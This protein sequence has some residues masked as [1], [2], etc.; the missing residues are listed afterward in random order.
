MNVSVLGDLGQGV[1]TEGVDIPKSS[2]ICVSIFLLMK[3]GWMIAIKGV[4]SI[5]GI[6]RR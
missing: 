1:C 5:G 3:V 6:M 2:N 4:V